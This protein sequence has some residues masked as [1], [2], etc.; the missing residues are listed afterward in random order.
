M[1]GAQRPTS[2]TIGRAVLS[3]LT[4]YQG[5]IGG[6][7]LGTKPHETCLRAITD[8]LIRRPSSERRRAGLSLTGALTR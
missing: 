6:D 5:G 2:R 7:S 8:I 1:S 3:D 4:Y